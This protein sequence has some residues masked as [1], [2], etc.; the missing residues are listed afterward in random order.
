MK[1]AFA[2]IEAINA[3]HD[4]IQTFD[5]EMSQVVLGTLEQWVSSQEN[6]EHNE[7]DVMINNIIDGG[8]LSNSN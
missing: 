8:N 6:V 1:D 7:C 3:S 2:A 5:H 4:A